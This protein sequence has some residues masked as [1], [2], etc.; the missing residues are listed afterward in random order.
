M[1]VETDAPKLVENLNRLDDQIKTL[2]DC[3]DNLVEVID[4][5]IDAP[6][7]SREVMAAWLIGAKFHEVFETFPYLYLNAMKGSGKTRTAK[8]LAFMGD[9][10]VVTNVTESVLFREKRMIFLDESENVDSDERKNQQQLLNSGYKRGILEKRSVRGEKDFEVKNYDPY[11]PIGII[12]IDGMNDVTEDRSVKIVLEK[13]TDRSR[14]RRMEMFSRDSQA[15]KIKDFLCVDSVVS[16]FSVVSTVNVVLLQTYNDICDHLMSSELHNIS[17]NTTTTPNYTNYTGMSDQAAMILRRLE[18]T[19]I[20]G[21][22]LELWMPLFIV[23]SHISEEVFERFVGYADAA[24]EQRRQN[25]MME[26][27]DVVLVGFL[28]SW[29]ADRRPGDYYMVSDIVADFNNLN[30][31]E[32]DW[33]NPRWVG[34]ALVRNG[35]R[36][37]AKRIGKGME[38]I[39]DVQKIKRKAEQF[40]LVEGLQSFTSNMKGTCDVCKAGNRDLVYLGKDASSDRACPDCFD[41]WR[42]VNA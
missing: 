5:Y 41:K 10:D 32:D 20:L 2:G 13:S 25:N 27:K 24:S 17:L 4:R 42:G 33:F 31:G 11:R 9:G 3:F 34:R 40:G 16:E 6:V 7:E 15:V 19:S 37:K 29:M 14:T 38:V 30:P 26:N 12:N 28:N 8:L 23:T 18:T 22:D 21:R 39:L 36:R 1:D 35:L